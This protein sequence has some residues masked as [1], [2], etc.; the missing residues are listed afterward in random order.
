LELLF[1]QTTV[2]LLL[3]AVGYVLLLQP[4][5]DATDINYQQN[6]PSIQV[7]HPVKIHK[8]MISKVG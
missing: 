6:S 1:D 2:F 4:W 5:M 3:T 8:A 7:Y